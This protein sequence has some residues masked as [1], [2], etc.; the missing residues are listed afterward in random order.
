MKII[1]VIL[2]GGAGTR[3]WP[4][5]KKNLPKQFID[6]GG[7]TL[8]GRTLHR[9]K[10]ST[11]D[12]PIITTNLAYLS[13][14]KKYLKKHKIK[15][16]RIILEPFKKNTAPAIL[17]SVLIKD[18][19]FNQPIIF[20]PSDNLIGKPNKFNKSVVEHKKYLDNKNIFIFGIKPKA[21]SSEYGYFVTKKISR[22]IN[23]VDKFIEKPKKNRIKEILKKKGYMNSGMFFARKDSIIRNFSLHQPNIFKHCSDSVRHPSVIIYQMK[24]NIELSFTF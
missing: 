6:W 9:I 7:W 4:K 13:L 21:P 23:K 19:P 8:L 1:P 24:L 12:H 5:S 3:L 10:G 15:K 17:S 2:C 18:I 16:Y 22:N 11:F 14:V 20:F